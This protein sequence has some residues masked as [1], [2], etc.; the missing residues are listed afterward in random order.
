[1]QPIYSAGS[2]RT[3]PADRFETQM[4]LYR[5][6]ANGLLEAHPEDAARVLES[7]PE[8]EVP[9]VL[10]AAPASVAA[11][12]VR[13]MAPNRAATVMARLGPGRAGAIVSDLGLDFAANILRRMEPEPR[14]AL[15]GS[16]TGDLARS[17]R[18]LLSFPEG[19]AGAM[20]DPTVLALPGDLSVQEA[21]AHMRAHPE[22]VRY[23]LYVVDRD[24]VLVGVLNLRELFL[25]RQKELLKTI[26]NPRVLSIPARS[27]RHE[28][29][30]HPAWRDARSV[31]VVDAGGVY[32]GAIRYQ[33]LRRLEGELLE[34]VSGDTAST[35]A[36]LGDLFST[37]VGGVFA[38]LAASFAPT[39]P[40]RGKHEP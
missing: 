12:T 22:A 31:P 5:T 14:E 18:S 6:L 13:R 25:A 37:G 35:I 24:R 21:H 7:L 9:A 34:G 36:A 33:T 38:A 19:T 11:G 8:A 28:I 26:A 2:P 29:L 15:M 16:L 10:G 30:A 27:G 40:G 32:L 39:V 23:N 4:K 20:M 3:E 1:M 17:L